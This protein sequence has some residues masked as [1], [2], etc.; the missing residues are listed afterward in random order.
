VI[1]VNPP[2]SRRLIANSPQVAKIRVDDSRVPAHKD[3]QHNQTKQCRELRGGE[4]ILD[5][6]AEL[7]PTRVHERQ[8]NDQKHAN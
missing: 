3:A 2:P 7:Q 1:A 8:Q 5:Q 4:S 6:L